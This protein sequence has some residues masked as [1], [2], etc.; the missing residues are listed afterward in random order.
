MHVSENLTNGKKNSIKTLEVYILR[1]I[2]SAISGR[3]PLTT[4][5]DTVFSLWPTYYICAI[6]MLPSDP[7]PRTT[8]VKLRVTLNNKDPAS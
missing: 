2:P 7:T 4:D 8:D 5:R 3:L 6:F 1:Y